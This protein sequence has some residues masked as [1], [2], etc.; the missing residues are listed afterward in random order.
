MRKENKIILA[1]VSCLV[2][3]VA[4]LLVYFGKDSLDVLISNFF[5]GISNNF[6]NGF[7]IFLGYYSRA[8]LVLI[9]I[10]VAGSL[11]FQKRKRESFFF[12]L[13]LVAG[14]II[15]DVVKLIVGRERPLL[16]MINYSGFSFPSGH[17]TFSIILFSLIIYFYKDSIKNKTK[18]FIFIAVNVL[19]I[20][21]IGFSRIYLNAHWFSDVIGG[22]ALGFFVFVLGVLVLKAKK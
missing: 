7:F 8:I 18:K 12:I 21:L 10:V 13:I 4:L 5:S 3:I 15:T 20:L 1:L 22:Y 2:F 6:A 11:Y 9:A 17:S 19:A 14:E 16:Q